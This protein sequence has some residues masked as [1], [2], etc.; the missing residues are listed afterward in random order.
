V[1][2]DLVARPVREEATGLLAEVRREGLAMVDDRGEL[3]DV[4]M[5]ED[6]TEGHVTLLV[7]EFL[8]EHARERPDAP[9]PI[10]AIQEHIASL[11]P[12]HRQYWRA[13]ARQ[14]GA[15]VHLVAT[16]LERLVALGL[17]RS[18]REGNDDVVPRPL[19]AR[20]ALAADDADDTSEAQK[21][22]ARRKTS[23][24]RGAR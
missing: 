5:P 16:A 22:H 18:R 24:M 6:G 17:V 11:A 15:E 4:A 12:T 8:A 3:S 13:E 14:P 23:A 2:R 19:I 1:R 21:P 20:Y 10:E 9:L 7:A